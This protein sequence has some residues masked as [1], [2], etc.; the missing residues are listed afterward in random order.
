MR[1]QGGGRPPVQQLL[2][3]LGKLISKAYPEKSWSMTPFEVLVAL[4]RHPWQY[5]LIKIPGFWVCCYIY[6][7]LGSL[8]AILNC[9]NMEVVC[10][11]ECELFA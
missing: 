8:H 9:Q 11:S 6:D 10:V 4:T 1:N 2:P 5:Q 7:I 3:L